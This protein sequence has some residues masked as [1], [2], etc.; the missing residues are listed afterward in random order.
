MMAAGRDRGKSS[1][2]RAEPVLSPPPGGISRV[3]SDDRQRYTHPAPP[4]TITCPI[5][6]TLRGCHIEHHFAFYDTPNDD[7]GDLAPRR[8]GI[9]V[10]DVVFWGR[11]YEHAIDISAGTRLT[12]FVDVR[13]VRGEVVGLRL[14]PGGCH[15]FPAEAEA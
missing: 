15:I 12:G 1:P 8:T 3:H 6:C 2:Q 13:A 11:G 9:R 14:D 4:V 5:S 7:Q 10:T